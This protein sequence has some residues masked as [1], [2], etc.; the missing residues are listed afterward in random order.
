[1]TRIYA[2]YLCAAELDY[3]LQI[4]GLAR[5]KTAHEARS[6]LSPLFSANIDTSDY[7]SPLDPEVDMEA[8]ENTWT[9]LKK[10]MGEQALPIDHMLRVQ[11]IALHLRGRI[12]RMRLPDN[13]LPE[14]MTIRLGEVESLISTANDYFTQA[15]IQVERS[16][17]DLNDLHDVEDGEETGGQSTS[18]ENGHAEESNDTCT[19][20]GGEKVHGT[21][22]VE[23]QL[24]EEFLTFRKRVLLAMAEN[25]QLNFPIE[26]LQFGAFKKQT[27]STESVP[28]PEEAHVIPEEDEPLLNSTRK[29]PTKSQE[30]HSAGA[31]QAPPTTPYQD[32]GN[33]RFSTSTKVACLKMAL[34]QQVIRIHGLTYRHRHLTSSRVR[35]HKRTR[36]T[37]EH[38]S[39]RCLHHNFHK[40]GLQTSLQ[41]N[42]IPISYHI[43]YQGQIFSPVVVNINKTVILLHHLSL[44]QA[45][46]HR[47]I[48]LNDA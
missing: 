38:G 8:I 39:H 41:I 17:P 32:S 19:G 46:A 24:H 22:E 7:V 6:T 3:E 29:H 11:S 2:K 47:A 26:S 21:R 45:W 25:P 14:A 18:E 36:T 15:N 20:V 34:N 9:R 31:Q 44:S 35:S 12:N 23:A 1:M 42:N 27:Q 37:T 10:Y 13:R 16:Y 40:I 28:H 4:R 30:N 48:Q 5:Q 43:P 33:V